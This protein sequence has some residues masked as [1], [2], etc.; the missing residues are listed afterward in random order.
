MWDVVGHEWAVQRLRAA[1]TNRTL[2]QSHLLIGPEHVGKAT[3]ARALAEAVLGETSRAQRLVQ[4][5]KHP[6]L[7]WLNPEDDAIKVEAVRAALH[8]LTLTPVEASHRVLVIEEAQRM[9]E[10]SQNALLKT[11]E[12]PPPTALMVLVAPNTDLLLPTIVSR[13]QVLALRPVPTVQIAEALAARG[14]PQ[15]QATFIARLAR[16]RVGWALRAAQDAALLEA[17]TKRL[18]DLQRLLHAG[19]AQRFAFAEALA[20]QPQDEQRAT[21]LEWLFFWRDVAHLHADRD[22]A[23][24]NVDRMAQLRALQAAVPLAQVTK[25]L[26]ALTRTLVRLEANVNARLAFDVLLLQLPRF[27]TSAENTVAP[28]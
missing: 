15:E 27:S 13:C 21:L 22:A 17:R 12:E 28:S 5:G 10:A 20:R 18:D 11:L 9:T 16:G 6:D 25:L 26:R 7:L 23:V 8:A 24:L 3:L 1:L 2:A 19:Y 14:V 4:Q